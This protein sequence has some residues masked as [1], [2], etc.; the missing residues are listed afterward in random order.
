MSYAT[1][2]YSRLYDY[3]QQSIISIYSTKYVVEHHS[4]L[5]LHQHLMELSEIVKW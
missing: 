2:K 3:V 5:T 4:P 1:G